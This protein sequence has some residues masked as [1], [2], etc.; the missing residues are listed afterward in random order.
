MVR[1][2]FTQDAIMRLI[3]GMGIGHGKSQHLSCFPVGSAFVANAFPF[4][5]D[6]PALVYSLK[7]R[8]IQIADVMP[9]TL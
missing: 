1:D 5:L 2:V 7:Y 3:G 6:A 8:R 9:R 4:Y